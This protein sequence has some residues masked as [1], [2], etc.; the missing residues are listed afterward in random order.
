VSEPHT[1]ATPLA[2]HISTAVDRWN[3]E[4]PG[5]TVLQVLEALEQVRYRLT[6][7]FLEMSHGPRTGK[8]GP[9]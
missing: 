3:A 9:S 7:A 4:H 8:T 5:T 6:E 1:T 2:L